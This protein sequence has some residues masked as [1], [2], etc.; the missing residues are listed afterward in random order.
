MP[1]TLRSLYICYLTLDDPLV[2]TQVVAYLEGLARRGHTMHLL[3]FDHELE[4]ERR[5]ELTARLRRRGIEWH[6]LRYHKRPSLPATIYDTLVGAVTA[7]RIMRR[8]RLEALHARNHVPAAMGLIARRLTRCKLIF[9]LRGLMAEEYVDA[10]IWRRDGLPYRITDR[11]QRAAIERADGVVMLTQAVRRHLFGDGAWRRPL[12]VIPCCTDTESSNG[13]LPSQTII[14]R[15]LGLGDGPVMIYVG[16][17]TG[18]YMEREMVDFFASASRLDPDL[19]FLILTQGDAEPI[20]NELR[21][22]AVRDEQYLIARAEPEDVARYLIAANFGI[23]FIRPCFSK[24]SSSPTKIAEYLH[25]GLPV[26]ST[27]GIGDVDP[28]LEEN[29]VGVLVDDFG[30][31]AYHAA[32]ATIRALASDPDCRARCRAVAREQLSL[33]NVGVPRYDRLYR[34]VAGA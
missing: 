11:V 22:H 34:E 6:S 32:A 10:G 16:K 2:H 27:R 20:R 12:A 13:R 18:W 24:I 29:R 25:A 7:A 19:V 21:R 5:R 17:F 4:P 33:T 26:L 14:R 23:S 8:H 28:L 9:D 31:P 1:E 30:A 3:T 15:E